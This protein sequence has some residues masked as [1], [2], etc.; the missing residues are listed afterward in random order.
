M[1]HSGNTPMPNL[2]WVSCTN[3][4]LDSKISNDQRRYFKPYSVW[5]KCRKTVTESFNMTGMAREIMHARCWNSAKTKVAAGNDLSILIIDR[6]ERAMLG[7]IV[8]NDKFR[9]QTDLYHVA[10]SS[11]GKTV[12]AAVG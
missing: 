7:K 2:N 12:K 11:V 1:R 5:A 8:S 10:F 4:E 3:S 6:N 9:P